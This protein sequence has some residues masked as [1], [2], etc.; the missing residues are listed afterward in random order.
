MCFC[1][2]YVFWIFD[3]IDNQKLIYISHTRYL[4][5]LVVKSVF[6]TWFFVEFIN[7][8]IFFR[9]CRKITCCVVYH[10]LY[11]R[12]EEY[13]IIIT[14]CPKLVACI[15]CIKRSSKLHVWVRDPETV[16][17]CGTVRDID[18][19]NWEIFRI[20]FFIFFF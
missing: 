18:L 2:F 7:Y 19:R 9:T 13:L 17:A 6:K 1:Y 20:D 11:E 3:G 10:L 16:V 5:I 4:R 8:W 12:G 15:L 14:L